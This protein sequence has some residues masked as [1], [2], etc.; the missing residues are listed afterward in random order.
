MHTCIK[1]ATLLPATIS[2]K[3]FCGLRECKG[4]VFAHQCVRCTTAGV[5]VIL[6]SFS[7]FLPLNY[8]LKKTKYFDGR[9]GWGPKL[10]EHQT[11]QLDRKSVV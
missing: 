7:F 6:I 1:Q 10:K 4:N 2:A 5:N 8:F 3:E 9:G 11:N